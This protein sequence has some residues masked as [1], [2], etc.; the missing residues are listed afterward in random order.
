MNPH[1]FCFFILLFTV[2]L[3]S[4][5]MPKDYFEIK[6]RKKAKEYFFE[7][8]Y[9]LSELEN[10]KILQERNIIKNILSSNILH[11]NPK[12]REFSKLLK[13]KK[14]YRIN[15]LY[16]LKSYMMK[17]DI[18]PPAMVLAQ[19]AIESG[20]GKSRFMREANNIFGHWTYNPKIGMIPKQRDEGDK[21]FI[22]VFKSLQSSISAY[23]LNL[24]RNP[25]YK[26]FQKKRYKIRLDNKQ[27]TGLELSQTMIN[28]SGIGKEYLVILKTVIEKNELEK[29]DKKFYQQIK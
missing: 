12:S 21:H 8:I 6:D 15:K 1:R 5:G 14:K 9:K 26:T 11:I 3:F 10:K 13:I 22:R 25:A 24:N 27:A 2:T 4:K 23:M 19:A 16:N 17:I 7:Y 29:Y 28:Y 18:I 20:W